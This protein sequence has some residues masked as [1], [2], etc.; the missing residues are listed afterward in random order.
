MN[1]TPHLES[2]Q[3]S[4]SLEFSEP[5]GR[6]VEAKVPTSATVLQFPRSEPTTS[7]QRRIIEQLIRTR[8]VAE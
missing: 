8:V 5:Q 7:F 1:E 4:L 2:R 3:L 6:N